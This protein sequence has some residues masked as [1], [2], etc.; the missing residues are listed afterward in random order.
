MYLEKRNNIYNE[1]LSMIYVLTVHLFDLIDI[2]I[3]FLKISQRLG[4]LTSDK[5]EVN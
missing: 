2:N 3:F 5:T 1:F 4:N